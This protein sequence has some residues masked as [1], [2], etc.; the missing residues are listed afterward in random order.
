M[1]FIFYI[2]LLFII[3]ISSLAQVN[4][5]VSL[6]LLWKHQFEFAGYYVAKEKGY[7]NDVGLDVNIKEYDFNIDISKDVDSEKSTFGI[8]YPSI[9]LDKAKGKNILLLNALLQDSP[10]VLV[11]LKSSNIK[12]ISDFKGKKIRVLDSEM[13]TASI[14]SMLYA[15]NIKYSD[16]KIIPYKYDINELIDK[17]VDLAAVFLTNEI[18][19]LKEK[20]ISCKIWDPKDYGF[21]F[22]DDI[23]FTS[24]KFAT[25]NPKKVKL[26]QQASLKG[27]EYAFSHIDETINLI[28]KKYNTQHKSK[29]ALLYEANILK[30][31]ALKDNIALGNIDKNKIQRIYDVY[32][33]MGF[34]TKV[35]LDILLFKPNEKINLSLDE[36]KYLKNKQ[37]INMCIDP[38]WMPYE[39]LQISKYDD[40]KYIGIGAEYIK[41]F[42]EKL[43]I[44]FKLIKTSSWNESKQFAKERKCDILV[45]SSNTEKRR[46]YMNITEPYL[47][48]PLVI[49]TRLNTN[50]ITNFYDLKGVKIGIT[51]GYSLIN[52]L[53]E[54]YPFLDIVETDNLENGLKLVAK[55]KLFGQIDAISSINY[56]IQNRFW[57][58]LKIGGQFKE[59]YKLG[60]AIRKDDIILFGIMNKAVQNIN[61][62]EKNEIYNK[63]NKIDIIETKFDYELLYYILSF[64]TFIILYLL[65]R[66]YKLK[67]ELKQFDELLDLTVEAML[68]TKNNICLNVNRSAVDMFGYINKTDMIASNIFKFVSK[69]SH[70][71]IRSNI[72]TH[73]LKEYEAVGLRDNNTEFPMQVY[74]KHIKHK[75]INVISIFDLSAIKKQERILAEQSKLASMGEMIGNIAHQWRQPLSVIST[76]ATG[77][78]VEQEFGILTDEFI[79]ETCDNINNQAQYLSN[80][81]NDFRNF[82]K[83]DKNKHMFKLEDEINTLFTLIKGTAKT[84]NIDII[85]N[86]EDNITIDGYENELTQCL[87]NLFNNSKDAFNEPN[88]I[89]RLFFIS[90]YIKDN[91]IHILI[92]DNAGGIPEDILPKVF[93]PYFTTKHQSQG[94]G[95][96]LHM[97]YNIIKDSMNGTINVHNVKF[98]YDGKNYNGAEFTIMLPLS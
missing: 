1:K 64:I 29:E 59:N 5:K 15:N 60:M 56:N 28:L 94:T 77:I 2:L 7:Y 13:Q 49:A 46:K 34:S 79:T 61:N 89:K 90:S 81:I 54:K 17:K 95:L 26:F 10:H 43:K 41:L 16:M 65:Y 8:G 83:K 91:K 14:K 57:G 39:K 86:L 21:D 48:E 67:K 55:K 76:G 71:Q 82:I 20:K 63:F 27:W 40:A 53:K 66:Q 68:I 11:S 24:N 58:E 4:H 23:L 6:Q 93:E 69:K 12:S 33:L 37:Q 18:Y 85:P 45:L 35:D 70:E 9:L 78:Q 30:K 62:I 88:V 47:I 50:F 22:Y 3:H 96:G 51:K 87:I 75:G 31:L 97:T 52:T 25:Q 73:K 44:N 38:N 19:I 74:I 84:Y 36:K 72:Q 42:S 92:K 98:M 80:T 32:N